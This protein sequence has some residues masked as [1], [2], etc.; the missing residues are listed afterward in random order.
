MTSKLCRIR[1]CK[2]HNVTK[3]EEDGTQET[4]D[5]PDRQTARQRRREVRARPRPQQRRYSP[6]TK[7]I[8]PLRAR[9]VEELEGRVALKE[10]RVR[11]GAARGLEVKPALGV[12]HVGCVRSRRG[13]YVF[14]VRI[15]EA[16]RKSEDERSCGTLKR[17]STASERGQQALGG[18]ASAENRMG[19]LIRG[20]LC[21]RVAAPR[22]DAELEDLLAPM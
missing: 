3:E 1:T 17:G 12:G 21:F 22:A 13:G 9:Q 19:A 10:L 8:Q 15:K 7:S 18:V 14:A 4:Q 6:A 20:R 11:D 16:M 5:E 2:H